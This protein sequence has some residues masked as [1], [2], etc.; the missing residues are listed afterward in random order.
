VST[1][2]RSGAHGGLT[3]RQ[4]ALVAGFAY[5][6]NPV[7]YAE[8]SLFPKLVTHGNIDQTL[9]TIGT[10]PGLF[11]ALIVC[12]LINYIG[13]V[14]IAWALYALF[15]PVNRALSLLAAWFQL[16]YTAIAFV[17]VLD[18]VSV[19]HTITTPELARL[20]GPGPLRA[21]IDL[22]LHTFRYDWSIGLVFFAIHL[23][24]IGYLIY[25]STY[26]PK[27]I[28]II[29]VIDGLGWVIDGLQ[30]Y[31]YPNVDLGLLS[32]TSLGELVFMLW[33]LIMGWRI[34]DLP[35]G[36]SAAPAHA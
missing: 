14:V 26:V 31:L 19:Y 4:A 3:L 1:N 17:G 22:L 8:F 21:Q 23:V 32:L 6:F 2:N 35:A 10:H 5:L 30:P 24:L 33:L 13:D 11:G 28:G 18:L 25:R 20:F 29:L 34:K 7:S 15:A 16:V 36:Q 27:I 12:Y 9:Q